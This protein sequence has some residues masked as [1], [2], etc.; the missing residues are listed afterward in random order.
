MPTIEVRTFIKDH[1]QDGWL[2]ESFRLQM[3]EWYT[4][5]TPQNARDINRLLSNEYH[6]LVRNNQT[7]FNH[8]WVFELVKMQE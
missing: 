3:T 1:I 7:E 4:S 8:A 2:P 5:V 6:R